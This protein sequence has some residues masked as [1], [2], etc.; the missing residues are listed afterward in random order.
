MRAMRNDSDVITL[1]V[2]QLELS[3]LINALN[4]ALE[5]VEAW[6]FSTRVGVEPHT[7][8]TLQKQL[9]A[10]ANRSG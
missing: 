8:E 4:E 10:I 7:A 2:S 9:V 1:E 3:V 5:A 6:E